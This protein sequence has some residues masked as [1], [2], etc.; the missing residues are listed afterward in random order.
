[1]W[2]AV[3]LLVVGYFLAVLSKMYAPTVF[4]KSVGA[5]EWLVGCFGLFK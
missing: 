3:L 2:E 4:D 5:V 1:M